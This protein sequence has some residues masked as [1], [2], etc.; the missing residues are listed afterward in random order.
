MN[1]TLTET[2]R[3]KGPVRLNKY[4]R[5]QTTQRIRTIHTRQPAGSKTRDLLGVEEKRAGVWL[6]NVNI[7]HG[8]LNKPNAC[9]PSL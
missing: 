1:V 5:I 6:A 7:V 3:G 2:A 9:T 8:K 4:R